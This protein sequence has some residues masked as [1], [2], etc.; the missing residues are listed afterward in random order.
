MSTSEKTRGYIAMPRS[1]FTDP[2]FADEPFTEREAFLS[3]AADAHYKP[4][5]LRLRRGA[6]ELQ[7]GQLLASNR[8]LAA[9]W[10]WQ[11]A[12]VRRFLNRL[13]GR[14]ANDAP[15]DAPNRN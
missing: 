1:I 3:L 11:E 9:R 10:R 12:R 15:N 4:L 13:S 8:F 6:V 2:A 5:L 7:R 14:R